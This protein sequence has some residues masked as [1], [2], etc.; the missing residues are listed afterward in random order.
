MGTRPNEF[1]GAS[2]IYEIM[3][4][5]AHMG[6]CKWSPTCMFPTHS[7]PT[8]RNGPNNNGIEFLCFGL[9]SSISIST[10]FVWLIWSTNAECWL[11]DL[12]W[13]P[14]ILATCH[15]PGINRNIFFNYRNAVLSTVNYINV[16]QNNNRLAE[17]SVVP[18][19]KTRKPSIDFHKAVYSAFYLFSL[20]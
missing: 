3:H 16:R 10:N 1:R 20:P 8:H 4:V 6:C 14:S 7:F 12:P 11:C 18:H 15:H 19:S 5:H 2:S 17:P 9:D 13:L